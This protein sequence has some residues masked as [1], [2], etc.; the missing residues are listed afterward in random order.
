MAGIQA[1][2]EPDGLIERLNSILVLSTVEQRQ[3]IIDEAVAALSRIQ[4]ERDELLR[5]TTVVAG[6]KEKAR[7]EAAE[8][9]VAELE[10]AAESA[11][12]LEAEGYK[13]LHYSD[14]LARAEA[15]ESRLEAAALR[16][17]ETIERCAQAAEGPIYKERYRGV[18][19]H[20]WSAERHFKNQYGNGRMDAAEAIRALA[21][22]PSK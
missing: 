5:L 4:A 12:Q 20:N 2:D 22:E 17:R 7:A 3:E 6:M 9:R 13:A 8:Q 16:E 21:Q 15:A 11:R 1:W 14:E 19:G 18:E 10:R